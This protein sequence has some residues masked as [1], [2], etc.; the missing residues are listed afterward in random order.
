MT[1]LGTPFVI[2]ATAR[3]ITIDLSLRSAATCAHCLA[4]RTT[5]R[6][7]THYIAC[8]HPTS[9]DGSQQIVEYSLDEASGGLSFLTTYRYRDIYITKVMFYQ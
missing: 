4:P 5:M 2:F 8:A 6:V 9:D 7:G 3:D 1:V